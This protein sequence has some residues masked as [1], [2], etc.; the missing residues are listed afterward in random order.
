MSSTGSV[1]TRDLYILE[2]EKNPLGTKADKVL[3]ST[4]LD[5][6]YDDKDP[7][8][9]NL[10]E[11]IEELKIA[12]ATG[13]QVIINFPVT[14]VNNQTGDVVITKSS[15]GMN[16]VDNTSDDEKP[17]SDPQR[18]TIMD[19]LENYQFDVD[20]HLLYEHLENTNNPHSVSFEQINATGSVTELIEHLIQSHNTD[21]SAHNN[22]LQRI[23][24][25]NHNIAELSEDVDTRIDAATADIARHYDD[26]N[27]HSDIMDRK[28]DSSRKVA[29]VTEENTNYDNYPSTRAMAIYV[30]NAI[31]DYMSSVD[32]NAGIEDII[33]VRSR[34]NLPRPSS[35]VYM[36]AYFILIGNSGSLEVAVCRRNGDEYSWD[37]TD[38]GI[39]SN[40]N[41]KYFEYENGLNVKSSSIGSDLLIDQT[42][43][44][45]LYDI[46]KDWDIGGGGGGHLEDYY[47]KEEI[48]AKHFI[49][50]IGI[51]PGTSNGTIRFYINDDITTMSEDIHVSGLKTL[52]YM[53]KVNENTI[54]L[55][56]ITSDHIRD[57]AIQRRHMDDKSVGADNL[58]ASY[59]RVFGNISD[60]VHKT[61]QEIPI[62]RLAELF[63]PVFQEILEGSSLVQM[64]EQRV[65]EIC[66]EEI[67]NNN[68]WNDPTKGVDFR[69]VDGNLKMCYDEDRGT[70]NVE[71][72]ESGD[73]VMTYEENEETPT[74][75]DLENFE[76]N[77]DDEDLGLH[78]RSNDIDDPG[79]DE[80]DDEIDD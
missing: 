13:G 8:H 36:R 56:S 28:E 1:L 21:N 71:I 61:V 5:Q 17:L 55:A 59:M 20:L 76:F 80:I 78:I 9:K 46:V 79:D 22:I 54:D 58:T 67:R 64:T 25:I 32:F 45:E 10:R 52:A 27:A 65:R 35:N 15:L 14:S 68:D 6:V 51:R 50:S 66:R 30:A 69:V 57:N 70:P 23:D 72:N 24:S 37:Y 49:S 11:I 19:I 48:D 38:T 33:I 43:L 40:L 41:S 39:Y 75:K 34:E 73:L 74:E 3:P 62:R 44:D 12:I 60:D 16:K 53:D 31:S 26:P 4:I 47:T 7:T 29:N 2:D 63:S 18:N 42:F 77:V